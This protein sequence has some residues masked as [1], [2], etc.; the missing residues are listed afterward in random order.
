MDLSHIRVPRWLSS[1]AIPVG[2]LLIALLTVGLYAYGIGLLLADKAAF[3]VWIR[4]DGLVE[5]LTFAALITSFGAAVV[6]RTGS[7][8]TTDNSAARAVWLVLALLFLFGALEEISYGQRVF[9]I[10]TPAF[11]VENT[12]HGADSFYNRQAET[13]VHNLVIGGV[14]VNKSVFGKMLT[15][16]AWL[17]LIVAPIVYRR[18]AR[19]RRFADRRG[20]PIVQN[21]Q[22]A[23]YLIVVLTAALFL[24]VHKV[25]ELVEFAS[26][27]VIL[28][29]IVHPL[30]ADAIPP[31]GI[32]RRRTPA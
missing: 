23:V 26:C 25:V 14:N 6:V 9:G 29:M 31:V 18:A 16:F 10:P 21:Y 5:W 8:R 12:A 28:T 32:P 27:G 17:Y 2:V 1:S 24:D 3:H 22:L 13:T 4:E 7:K 11:L 19:F 20:V 15:L 30:N